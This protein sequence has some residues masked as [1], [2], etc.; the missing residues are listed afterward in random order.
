MKKGGYKIIDFK[1]TALSGTA[2]EIP[3]IL[4]QIADNY[5]KPIMVSGVV[6]NGEL[7]DDA[8]ASVNDTEDTVVLTV[9]GGVI[10]VN[11]DDEVTFTSG[12][13]SGG[14]DTVTIVQKTYTTSTV[15]TGNNTST[16]TIDVSDLVEAHEK[17]VPVNFRGADGDGYI[18]LGVVY[19]FINSEGILNI[20]IRNFTSG[21]ITMPSFDVELMCIN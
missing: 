21:S 9:Y 3:G 1:G 15:M 6:L 11:E 5:N 12:S 13:P 14:G 8:Y 4:E 17:V 20:G 7:Q 19:M 16:F 10:T 2:V 18:N